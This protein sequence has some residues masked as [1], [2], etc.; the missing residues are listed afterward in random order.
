MNYCVA[1][2][3][4]IDLNNKTDLKRQ[5]KELLQY[6]KIIDFALNEEHI[7]DTTTPTLPLQSAIPI[8]EGVSTVL[9]LIS[10]LPREFSSSSIYNLTKDRISRGV[11]KAALTEAINTGKIKETQKGVGRRPSQYQKL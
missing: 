4:E 2:K 5:Q 10:S 7:A 9:K 6:L 8:N 11:V 1:V 3:L